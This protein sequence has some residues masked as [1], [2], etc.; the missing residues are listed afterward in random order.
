M[1]LA[2]AAFFLAF[3]AVPSSLGNS[4]VLWREGFPTVASQPTAREILLTGRFDRNGNQL[5]VSRSKDCGSAH[6]P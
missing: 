4:V 6:K 5:V 3:I 1:R 2:I